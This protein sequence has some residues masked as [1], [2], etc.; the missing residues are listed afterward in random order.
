[1]TFSVTLQRCLVR[2]YWEAKAS[3]LLYHSMNWKSNGNEAWNQICSLMQDSCNNISTTPFKRTLK[4]QLDKAGA[5]TPWET[6]AGTFTVKNFVNF[7]HMDFFV[8]LARRFVQYWTLTWIYCLHTAVQKNQNIN[9]I[10][11]FSA[12]TLSFPRRAAKQIKKANFIYCRK[13]AYNHR[14]FKVQKFLISWYSNWFQGK[15]Y[16]SWDF[17]WGHKEW[18]WRKPHPYPGVWV[19][20]HEDSPTPVIFFIPLYGKG[21]IFTALPQECRSTQA[22]LNVFQKRSQ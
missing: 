9:M 16:L 11:F 1:M 22:G 18:A 20:L 15:F 3:S 17:R 12:V 14:G 7:K 19:R 8:C 5:S 6:R 10:L 21:R 2:S 13:S 4:L